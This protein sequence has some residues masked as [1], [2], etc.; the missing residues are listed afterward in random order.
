MDLAPKGHNSF[1]LYSPYR[2]LGQSASKPRAHALGYDLSPLQGSGG[3]VAGIE[4]ERW[5]DETVSKS[6][7]GYQIGFG[8]SGASHL[9][10]ATIMPSIKLHS[11][12]RGSMNHKNQK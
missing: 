1:F 8:T 9:L 6:D 2:A 7:C 12:F 11:V 3:V 10:C 4:D 5:A